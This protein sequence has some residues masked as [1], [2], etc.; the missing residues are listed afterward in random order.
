MK[1]MRVLQWVWGLS[2]A[3]SQAC[4]YAERTSVAAMERNYDGNPRSLRKIKKTL[5]KRGV[6]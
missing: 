6:A 3:E 5:A 1:A 4:E 2:P